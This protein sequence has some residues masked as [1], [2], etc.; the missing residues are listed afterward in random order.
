MNK[1]S[2]ASQLFQT[3]ILFVVILVATAW[4]VIGCQHDN[5]SEASNQASGS[6]TTSQQPSTNAQ[7]KAPDKPKPAELISAVDRG[8]VDDLNALIAK[9]VDVNGT[10]D[11][12]MT[13]LM[14]AARMARAD[15]VPIL[16]AA[17]ADVNAEDKDGETALTMAKDGNAMDIQTALKEAGAKVTQL[18]GRISRV[19][20]ARRK[21]TVI[22]WLSEKEAWDKQHPK[23][24]ALEKDTVVNSLTSATVAEL[25]SG[26]KGVKDTHA[27]FGKGDEYWIRSVAKLAGQQV[28]VRWNSHGVVKRIDFVAM[29]GG[30][31]MA[32]QIS[33]NGFKVGG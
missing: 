23:V 21:I 29:F 5:A 6:T 4:S 24:F 16:I 1:L 22:P 10:G 26:T 12:G 28:T 19:D 15:C 7:V 17:H 9:G 31:Q 2:V 27:V 13:A 14:H 18:D 32:G 11:D 33:S 30:Q 3:R 8:N 20:A 25:E